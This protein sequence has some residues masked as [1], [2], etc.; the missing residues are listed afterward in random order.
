MAKKVQLKKHHYYGGAAILVAAG[1]FFFFGAFPWDAQGGGQPKPPVI[2]NIAI[3]NVGPNSAD[4][5]WSTD[6]VTSDN[7]CWTSQIPQKKNAMKKLAWECGSPTDGSVLDK[8]IHISNLT[9]NTQYT[10]FVVATGGS[11]PHQEVNS[12]LFDFLTTK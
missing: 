7:V 4:I 1:L 11:T 10:Y 8:S 2:S 3:T 12:D 5:S 9:P 6:R